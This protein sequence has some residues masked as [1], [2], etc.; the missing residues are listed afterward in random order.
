MKRN[1]VIAILLFSIIACN[2]NKTRTAGWTSKEEENW[3]KLC[4]D[5]VGNNHPNP[6]E[7]CSCVLGKIKEKYKTNAEADRYGTVEEGKRMGTE[8]IG[9]GVKTNN[10]NI[11]PVNNDNLNNGDNSR[12]T[13]SGWSE[14][15]KESWTQQCFQSLSKQ[16]WS[17]NAKQRYCDCVRQKL[18]QRYANFDEMNMNG[19][20]E[21]GVEY[22][23]QCSKALTGDGNE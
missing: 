22:G 9:N 3:I 5:Q 21:E 20:Y 8:C 11:N 14:T 18:E 4:T 13:G 2:N 1:S 19:T 16:S 7:Y 10:D 23:K 12:N 15:D 17:E 6:R